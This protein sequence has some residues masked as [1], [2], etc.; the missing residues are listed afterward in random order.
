MKYTLIAQLYWPIWLLFRAD[1][2]NY[3]GMAVGA[4][5]VGLVWRLAWWLEFRKTM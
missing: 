5:V 2:Q 4:V 1:D 3:T